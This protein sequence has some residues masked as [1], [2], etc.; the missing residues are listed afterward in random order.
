MEF[1]N[2]SNEE[3]LRISEKLDKVSDNADHENQMALVFSGQPLTPFVGQWNLH[4]S[5][6]D[7]QQQILEGWWQFHFGLHW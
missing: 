2:A 6:K 5:Q 1:Q 7:M 3:N 4:I